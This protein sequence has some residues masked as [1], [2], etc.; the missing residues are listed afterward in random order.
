MRKS[1]VTTGKASALRS[2]ISLDL[3][4]PILRQAPTWNP[5]ATAKMSIQTA[6]IASLPR[7]LATCRPAFHLI[8][9]GSMPRSYR[10]CI[11]ASICI[12][13][14]C[15]MNVCSTSFPRISA[16]FSIPIR[17][18]LTSSPSLRARLQCLDMQL[19]SRDHDLCISMQLFPTLSLHSN[20]R[21]DDV[22]SSGTGRWTQ[23]LNLCLA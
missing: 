12:S 19:E 16:P 10:I 13:C 18:R 8:F 1:P 4:Q 7:P 15:T 20:V 5:S 23:L 14:V 22:D 3:R 17:Q 2:A 6:G 11:P 9:S 21:V